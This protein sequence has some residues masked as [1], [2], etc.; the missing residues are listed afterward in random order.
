MGNFKTTFV[1][2]A[3]AVTIAALAASSVAIA[4]SS[5]SRTDVGSGTR[6]KADIPSSE[7]V[8]DHHDGGPAAAPSGGLR[9]TGLDLMLILG[10]GFVLVASGVALS[11]LVLRRVRV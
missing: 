3:L 8:K 11:G 6:V 10:G 1:V 4:A 9:L 7:T 5:V 2:V